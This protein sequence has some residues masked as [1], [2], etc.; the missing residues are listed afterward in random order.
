MEQECDD[1]QHVVFLKPLNP[2]CPLPP[3]LL[4]R[5]FSDFQAPAGG[6]FLRLKYGM[7]FFP[8]CRVS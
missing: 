4:A 1:S 2:Q 3:V 8:G 7:G 6:L 5:P